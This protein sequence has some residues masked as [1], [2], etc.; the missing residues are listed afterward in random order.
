M[1]AFE[2]ESDPITVVGKFQFDV[3]YNGASEAHYTKGFK[4]GSAADQPDDN[5]ENIRRT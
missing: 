2:V 4:E 5:S 1:L 3:V